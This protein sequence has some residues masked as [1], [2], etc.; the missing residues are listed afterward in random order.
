MHADALWRPGAGTREHLGEYFLNEAA[1]LDD[2]LAFAAEVPVI[3]WGAVG[4][5]PVEE[6]Q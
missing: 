2:A 4:V 3:R 6:F 5:R 1:T